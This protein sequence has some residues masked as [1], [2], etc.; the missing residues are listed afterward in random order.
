[1]SK[2]LTLL[3]LFQTGLLFG[4]NS[5][6]L[7]NGYFPG[8]EGLTI[9]LMEY[10]DMISFHEQEIGSA[11]VDDSGRFSIDIT[12]RNTQYVF[13][14]MDHAR[15]G[16]F[17]EPGNT[18]SLEFEPVNFSHLDDSRNP[19]LD[20]WY[21]NYTIIEP[22]NTLNDRIDE[23]DELFHE[24]LLKNFSRIHQ[25]RNR[26][27]FDDFRSHT[28]SI[29]AEVDDEWFRDY[30]QYKYAYY[31]RT[32]NLESFS[33]QM[34]K[35]ILNRPVL[36]HNTQ[37][38]NYF[39]AVFD[40]Y[41]FA[42]SRNVKVSDLTHTVNHLNS[43]DALIDSLG[44]DTLLKNE[45]LREL[46]MVKALQDMYS[47]PDFI[48]QN[49]ESILQHVNNNS[50]FPEHRIIAGNILFEKNKLTRGSYAPDIEVYDVNGNAK[51]IPG[52]FEGKIIYMG[53]W[54]SWC[55]S[56]LLEFIAL[57]EVYKQFDN[58]DEVVFINISTE[59]DPAVFSAFVQSSDYPWYNFHFNHDF[60]IL[61]AYEVRSLPVYVIID[62]QG[63]IIDYP[64]MKPS[65]DII[66][67]IN[68]IL[69]RKN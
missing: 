54:A 17:V 42:G 30:Y 14:R 53:F 40:T 18:Y 15:M 27:L 61:D 22:E 65:G 28:D 39:N 38:M 25:G 19:Y 26:N 31:Y 10:G 2:I 33:A 20:P 45:R 66:E 69:K 21:F 52:D 56:C 64:A 58:H 34:N 59:R 67:R 29:F 51:Q 7:I 63:R 4:E 57:N 3:L 46:V 8:A 47:N 11:V 13:L 43:Y 68:R 24:F 9:R 1:M 12:R 41:I 49:V 35:Y 50:K 5:H 6:I 48:Q 16:L 62:D 44:K 32:A 55:E 23:F 60:R 36:Y 37:Y